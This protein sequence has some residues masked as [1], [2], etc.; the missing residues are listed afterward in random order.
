[1]AVL[2]IVSDTFLLVFGFLGF[3]LAWALTV[4]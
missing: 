4:V 3:Q 1:M 2:L